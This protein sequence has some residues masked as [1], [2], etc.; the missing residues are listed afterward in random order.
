MYIHIHIC[1]YTLYIIQIVQYQIIKHLPCA[2][3][4]ESNSRKGKIARARDS[5]KE[6]AQGLA[7]ATRARFVQAHLAYRM[8]LC[9]KLAQTT[10]AKACASTLRKQTRARLTQARD[11]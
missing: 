7:Q 11:L 2:S 8:Y 10:R 4:R 1:I 9:K 5:R 6:F 3:S